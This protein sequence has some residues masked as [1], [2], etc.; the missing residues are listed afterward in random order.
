M[1][2]IILD[3]MFMIEKRKCAYC[4]EFGEH[5]LFVMESRISAMERTVAR[6]ADNAHRPD[7]CMHDMLALL[8]CAADCCQEGGLPSLPAHH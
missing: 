6:T 4:S 1:L 8:G 3:A 5:R 2:L 7:E